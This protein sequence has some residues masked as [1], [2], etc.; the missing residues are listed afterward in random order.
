MLVF[1][2]SLATPITVCAADPPIDKPTSVLQFELVD[3]TVISGRTDARTLNI[4]ISSG[5]IVKIP[6][7]VFKELTVGLNDRAGLVQRIKKLI[8]SMT[9]DEL[10]ESAQNELI[11]LGPMATPIIESQLGDYVYPTV[12][13]VLNAHKAWREKHPNAPDALVKPLKPRS[14]ILTNANKFHGTITIKEFCITSTYGPVT[15]RLDD[16]YRIRRLTNLQISLAPDK[17]GNWE[18]KQRNGPYIEGKMLSQSL[19][20]QTHFGPISV[21]FERIKT[22]AFS[23]DRK[24]VRLECWGATSFT[25]Q[26]DPKVK[27]SIKT[28]K[29][30]TNVSAG[31]IATISSHPLRLMGHGS[32]INSIAF[33]PDGKQLVSGSFDKT[34]KLWNTANGKERLT[35][36]GHSGMVYSVAFSPDGKRLASGSDDKT[37]VI[38]DAAAGTKLFW[39]K[40]YRAPISTVAFSPDGKR[41]AVGGWSD[42]VE[43]WDLKSHKTLQ[44]FRGRAGAGSVVFSPDGK[45]LAAACTDHVLRVWDIA[46]AHKP[47]T[48]KGHAHNVSDVAFSPDG[49]RLAS[50]CLDKTARIWD[51]ATGKEL[52]ILKGHSH[53]VTSVAFSPDGKYLAS[54]SWDNT[55]KLWDTDTGENFFTLTGHGCGVLSVAFSPDG[56]RLASG[57]YGQIIKIWAISEQTKA[58]K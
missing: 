1:C 56:K 20:I 16:I 43:L 47:L 57:G 8:D 2:L 44:T 11:A 31:N 36:K 29:G 21:P 53:Q 51:A 50:A 46:A 55:I 45:R 35:I 4:K 40:A 9:S 32:Q 39:G 17:F 10:L 26:C 13:Q 6:V 25:G 38:W 12:R 15:V 5:N 30:Q 42:Y 28:H 19:R 27:I 52:F 23:A 41:L 48:L 37:T 33:S 7:S 58:R 49:K 24:T 22:A 3:G 18:V 34:I 54:G 14:T